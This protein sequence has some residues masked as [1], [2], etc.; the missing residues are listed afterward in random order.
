MFIKLIDIFKLYKCGIY[1]KLFYRHNIIT[2]IT[3]LYINHLKTNENLYKLVY[4]GII[5]SLVENN[6]D[7]DFT[8]RENKNVRINHNISCLE[9]PF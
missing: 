9:S 7:L 6:N 3:R 5:L 4:W 1:F 8:F 2:G